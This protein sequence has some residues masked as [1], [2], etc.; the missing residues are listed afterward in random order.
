MIQHRPGLQLT[1]LIPRPLPVMRG[2][3]M[4]AFDGLNK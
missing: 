2:V 4:F 3:D 1:V